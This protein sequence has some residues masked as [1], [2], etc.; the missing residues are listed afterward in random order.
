[1]AS[2]MRP[3]V[4]SAALVVNEIDGSV[5]L[6]QRGK[7]PNYGKW[8][9]PG[10]KIEWG[11][12]IEDAAIREVKEETGLEVEVVERLGIFEI[13]EPPTHSVFVLSL[14]RVQGGVLQAGSDLM[15]VTFVP[16]RELPDVGLSEP[17]R[18]ALASLG[19]LRSDHIAASSDPPIPT[20]Q[21]Q[22]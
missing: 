11:E 18:A 17:C 13:L 15:H 3:H 16:W 14:A 2:A 9:M 7:E 1:M 8:V 21:G 19:Y 6:G 5:L 20:P 12:S 4:G 22:L 10:G